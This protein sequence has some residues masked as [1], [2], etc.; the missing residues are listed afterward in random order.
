MKYKAKEAAKKFLSHDINKLKLLVSD[1]DI[2][3]FDIFDTL[4][5]RNVWSQDDI[6]KLT[7]IISDRGGTMI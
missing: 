3:S 5:V 6:F 7:E 4:C 2:I 1:Y